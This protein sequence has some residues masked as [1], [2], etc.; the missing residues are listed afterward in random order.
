MIYVLILIVAFVAFITSIIADCHINDKTNDPS[1]WSIL[2]FIGS[3]F[4]FGFSLFS[5]ISVTT[6]FIIFSI[7]IVISGLRM[8]N[9]KKVIQFIGKIGP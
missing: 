8:L 6:A 3:F 1:M 7:A 2:H 4:V 9:F 5:V